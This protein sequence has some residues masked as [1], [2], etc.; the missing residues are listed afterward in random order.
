MSWSY[1]TVSVMPADN[2]SVK[3]RARLNQWEK[4][5]AAKLTV[6]NHWKCDDGG[7]G[8][9]LLLLLWLFRFQPEAMLNIRV[10]RINLSGW[11]APPLRSVCCSELIW[12]PENQVI[13]TA[14][15]IF[16]SFILCWSQTCQSQFCWLW[17]CQP[18][19]TLTK[20]FWNTF[21]TWC[22]KSL[23]T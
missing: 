19:I 9:T 4:K 11:S 18:K 14:S 23:L 10:A 7:R 13:L 20:L 21:Q 5:N 6:K 16:F 1:S 12:L 3:Q 22:Y 8:V 17:I 2:H 15:L